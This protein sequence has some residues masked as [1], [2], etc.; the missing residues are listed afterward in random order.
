MV[1]HHRTGGR[2]RRHIID[3][4]FANDPD[5]AP[6]TQAVSIFSTSTN[7]SSPPVVGRL[8]PSSTDTPVSDH[9]LRHPGMCTRHRSV[10]DSL[11][12]PKTH[13]NPYRSYP[14]HRS[15]ESQPQRLAA[16]PLE[17]VAQSSSPHHL[18]TGLGRVQDLHDILRE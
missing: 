3:P 5:F 10:C 4:T 2:V 12:T 16:V 8:S 15:T 7:G 18:N 6:I 11:W 13:E 9:A 1:I 14:P 17:S